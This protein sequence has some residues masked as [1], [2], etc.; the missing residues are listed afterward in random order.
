MTMRELRSHEAIEVLVPSSRSVLCGTGG[1]GASFL[2]GGL[3]LWLTVRKL[4]VGMGGG[5]SLRFERG[6]VARENL[7]RRAGWDLRLRD[8]LVEVDELTNEAGLGDDPVGLL[9]VL[10]RFLLLL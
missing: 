5:G 10:P 3:M 7:S 9:E 4:F 2:V 6:N 1:Q 8:P